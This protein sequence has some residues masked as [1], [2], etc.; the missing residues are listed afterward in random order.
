M[1]TVGKHREVSIESEHL[2]VW[3]SKLSSFVTILQ[4]TIAPI[5]TPCRVCSES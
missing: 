4:D 5:I 2:T 3:S 1:Y